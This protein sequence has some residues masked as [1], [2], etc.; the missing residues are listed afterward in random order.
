MKKTFQS[1]LPCFPGFYESIWYSSD[2]EADET[3]A[4]VSSYANCG[5]QGEFPEE[6]LERFLADHQDAVTYDYD[7]YEA[8]VSNAYADV[9][10]EALA[11]A[12]FPNS[13]TF[14]RLDKPR[15]YNFRTDYAE[16]SYEIDADEL[17]RYCLDPSRVE[18]FK[19]YLQ[20]NYG[21]RPGFMPFHPAT[22]EYWTNLDTGNGWTLSVLVRFVLEQESGKG[23]YIWDR[24]AQEAIEWKPI[25]LS[26]YLKADVL[27]NYLEGEYD[28]ELPEDLMTPNEIAAEYER[29]MKQGDEYLRIMGKKYTKAVKDGK[30]N[31]IASLAKDMATSMDYLNAIKKAEESA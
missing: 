19:S 6:I 3:Y 7:E 1:I 18:A 30:E 27:F 28:D 10:S 25:L 15:Y 16:A 26:D 14:L 8:D 12:G 9:I 29:L 11:E 20:E 22:P 5:F 13:I 17:V 4:A 2:Y 21:E 23:E 24:L 31:A